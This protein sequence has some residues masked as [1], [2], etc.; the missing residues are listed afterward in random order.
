MY[1]NQEQGA[2]NDVLYSNSGNTF[3]N[4]KGY[5]SLFPL[6]LGKIIVYKEVFMRKGLI[7][8]DSEQLLKTIK[9]VRDPEQLWSQYGIRS[10]S[11]SDAYFGHG[12]DYWKG[13]IWISK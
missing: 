11:K 3:V 10:L 4:H 1:W 7:P 13:P 6:L 8:K 5:I 12:E 2:Y 9:T